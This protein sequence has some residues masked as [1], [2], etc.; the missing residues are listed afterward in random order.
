MSKWSTR[1]RMHNPRQ[2]CVV[3]KKTYCLYIPF[4]FFFSVSYSFFFLFFPIISLK[5]LFY[6]LILIFFPLLSTINSNLNQ[7]KAKKNTFL[8]V[9][10]QCQNFT[11][12][13]N[14]FVQNWFMHGRISIKWCEL[15]F[16]VLYINKFFSI[17]VLFS[18][19]A[20]KIP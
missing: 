8:C 17:L 10:P 14:T 5:K 13:K 19:H 9:F 3:S 7:T 12:A 6:F 18:T 15:G 16:A 20:V 2:G 1:I 11:L 4:S